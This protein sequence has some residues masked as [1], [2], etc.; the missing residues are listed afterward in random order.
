MGAVAWTFRAPRDAVARRPPSGLGFPL[1]PGF[2]KARAWRQSNTSGESTM[3]DTQKTRKS[4][5]LA[6]CH[7]RVQL[8]M[9]VL[10]VR[11]GTRENHRAYRCVAGAGDGQRVRNVGL[12]QEGAGSAGL[13]R[14]QL[15]TSRPIRAAIGVTVFVFGVLA[16]AGLAAWMMP[17]I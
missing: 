5:K 8:F 1:P 7:K 2:V 13:R 9:L 6:I 4:P 17:P 14:P 16:G 3:S 11:G 15:L 10:V 12:R